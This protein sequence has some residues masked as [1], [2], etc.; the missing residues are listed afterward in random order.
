MSENDKFAFAEAYRKLQPGADRSIVGFREA[1][2]RKVRKDLPKSEDKIV[3]LARL[4]FD[5]PVSS[6][7][8]PVWLE[9][10][11]KEKDGHFS[12][13]HDGNEARIVATILLA[14]M[15]ASGFAGT[16][17]L[18]L[19]GS[20]AGRRQT[21][22]Q[23]AIVMAAR[24]GLADMGRT[25]RLGFRTQ[26]A[27]ARWQDIGKTVLA[28][29]T[30]DAAT[31]HTALE[32]IVTE[33]K[34]SEARMV[35]KFNGALSALTNENRRLAEEVDLL[36]WRMGRWSYLLDRPLSEIHGQ[37]LPFVIGT[38]V[39]AMIH[40]LPGPHGALGII[41]DALGG[42]ANTRQTIKDTFEAVPTADR[43]ALLQDTKTQPD[44]IALL[45]AGLRLYDDAAI[46]ASIPALFAKY[47][48][49][50]ID[51][52]LTRFEIAV[53]AFYERMLIK[54]GWI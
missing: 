20:F 31:I 11:L 8:K 50:S 17:A 32:A 5:I 30:G 37:A 19:T 15:I 9:D 3:D 45:N 6:G 52:E 29:K 51:T 46:T 25:R 49:L 24:S 14:D 44:P 39:A 35:E 34:A 16:P 4:A 23:E 42:E 33:A 40:V 41:R 38:D 28:A 21:V 54:S 1:A 27:A 18:V 10:I 26:I 53:Q 2:H 13:E 36:W 22:D 47:G 48:G 43:A 7:Q 12:L